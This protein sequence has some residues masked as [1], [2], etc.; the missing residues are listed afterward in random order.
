[1]IQPDEFL[2]TVDMIK[3][4]SGRTHSHDG[5]QFTRLSR[6]SVADTCSAIQKKIKNKASKLVETCDRVSSEYAIQVVNKRIAVTPIANVGAGS[7]SMVS[8]KL[9]T[10]WMTS[11]ARLESIYSEVFL[12]M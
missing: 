2:E 11:L 6:E 10:L 5:D 12:L 1:M 3:R 9:P 4:K 7:I 8:S